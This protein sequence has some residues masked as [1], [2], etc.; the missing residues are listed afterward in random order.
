[1]KN[2]TT[3]VKKSDFSGDEI[4]IFCKGGSRCFYSTYSNGTADHFRFSSN[5]VKDLSKM[6]QLIVSFMN[7]LK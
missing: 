5:T 6:E 2:N 3:V 1:L 4:K 7:A